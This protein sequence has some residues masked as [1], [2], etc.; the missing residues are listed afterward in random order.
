MLISLILTSFYHF[1]F[2]PSNPTSFSI[3]V[4]QRRGDTTSGF[5]QN[6]H[7][8]SM[9]ALFRASIPFQKSPNLRP[10]ALLPKPPWPWSCWLS[11]KRKWVKVGQ[12]AF[13]KQGLKAHTY[14][15]PTLNGLLSPWHSISMTHIYSDDWDGLS[16][17]HN[18]DIT[19]HEHIESMLT[20]IND[21]HS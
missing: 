14:F 10:F 5:V 1:P 7:Q 17:T 16:S 13:W 8:T 6:T 19:E 9:Y 21:D 12:Q 2:R 20:E 4:I 11:V 18:F 15:L 3:L